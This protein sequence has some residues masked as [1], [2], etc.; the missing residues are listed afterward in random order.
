MLMGLMEMS[1]VF[2]GPIIIEVDCSTI[3]KEIQVGGACRSPWYAQLMDIN[4]MKTHFDKV[5]VSV[6]KRG[7][8]S[9]AHGIVAGRKD[10]GDHL[11]I[12]GV[13]ASVRTA[14]SSECTTTNA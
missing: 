9:L 1:K 6:I 2:N 5:D 11:L 7:Q 13:H 14:M 4:R 8:N 10:S 12:A 3:G